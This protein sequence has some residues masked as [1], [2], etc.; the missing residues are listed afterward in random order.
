MPSLHIQNVI[1]NSISFHY[2]HNPLSLSN[3]KKSL[4]VFSSIACNQIIASNKQRL[5]AHNNLVTMQRAKL[6]EA[7]STP[8]DFTL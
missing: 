3:E 7:M 1:M 8:R 6:K 5:E 4:S 2:I